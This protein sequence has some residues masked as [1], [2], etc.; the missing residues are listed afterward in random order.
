MLEGELLTVLGT[1]ETIKI[2]TRGRKTGLPHVVRV[3]YVTMN[4]AIYVLSGLKNSDWVLNAL[5]KGE[6]RIR[7]E[8][9][10]LHVSVKEAVEWEHAEVLEAFR[11]KYGYFITRNWYS[12]A[13]RCLKLIPLGQPIRRGI[14]KGEN[15]VTTT[16]SEW[17]AQGTSY[18]K[19]VALAFDSAAEEYDFTI[20]N[21]F[22]NTWIRK[23]SI[24][25]LL[26]WTSSDHTLL[27]IGCGTGQEAIEVSKHVK[28]IIATDISNEMIE[29]LSLK[30]KHR[31][32]EDKIIPVKISAAEIY[33]IQELLPDLEI[34]G[35]YSFNGPLNCEPNI[36][37]FAKHLWEILASPG[38][39]I[40]SIRNTVCMSEEIS[41]LLSFQF[42]K[43]APR[44]HRPIM[45]SVG[46]TDIPAFYYPPHFFAKSF[47]P[48]FKLKKL[49][50]LPVLLPPAYLNDYYILFRPY[51]SILEKIEELISSRFPFNLL[52]DQTLFVFQK[53][54]IL[55]PN[56]RVKK[57]SNF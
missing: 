38:Y 14:I 7:S 5:H 53:N 55:Q 50:G 54:D 6:A 32:L 21:N 52:G 25:E 57:H 8:E 49:I 29:I 19:S 56:L 51:T 2:I 33:R 36:K 15:D 9:Y 31:R 16:Y 13:S 23:K 37:T 35:C 43:L 39:F 10:L 24:S 30:L 41:H 44:R 27:E 22:I 12:S 34:N 48:Y 4:G 18:L 28:R 46:G 42:E 47:E 1:N 20:G 3:R 17:L 26:R 40:C 11:K 45:V